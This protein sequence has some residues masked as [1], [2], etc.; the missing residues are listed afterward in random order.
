MLLPMVVAGT[1]S[2]LFADQVLHKPKKKSQE[3]ELVEALAKYMKT[4]Q[5][6]KE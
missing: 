2:M 1:V 3:E 4:V 6:K 5:A